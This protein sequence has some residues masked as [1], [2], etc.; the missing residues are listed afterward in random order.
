[1]K[2]FGEPYFEFLRWKIV[3][4][5]FQIFRMKN[6]GGLYFKILIALQ[7]FIIPVLKHFR[8]RQAWH[9]DRKWS[10]TS[11]FPSRLHYKNMLA[12]YE[13]AI[14]SKYIIRLSVLVG[15]LQYMIYY[16][17]SP[18]PHPPH[19]CR[20]RAGLLYIVASTLLH[21]TPWCTPWLIMLR[22][23]TFTL[24][25]PVWICIRLRKRGIV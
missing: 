6:F 2:K 1:M 18:S 9:R 12:G 20:R 21:T 24:H 8:S 7:T 25:T 23:F 10:L 3:W 11:Q 15:C 14:Y 5:L 13:V 22:G 4:T 17:K 19:S 16:E